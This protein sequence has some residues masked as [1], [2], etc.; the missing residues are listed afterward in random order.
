M[1]KVKSI[2]RFEIPEDQGVAALF[3]G[4]KCDGMPF[5]SLSRKGKK[6]T[7]IYKKEK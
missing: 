3:A 7:V 1:K 5:Q 4:S 2:K 6:V